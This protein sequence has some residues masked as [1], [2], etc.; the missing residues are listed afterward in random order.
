MSA[1]P[2]VSPSAVPVRTAADVLAG[3]QGVIAVVK[4]DGKFY[5]ATKEIKVT[6]GGCGG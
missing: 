1:T 3:V 5:T 2:A 4:A 6:L